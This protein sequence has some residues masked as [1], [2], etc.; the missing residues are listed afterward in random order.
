MSKK[1]VLGI[2]HNQNQATV[3]V[4]ALVRAGFP[5]SDISV[6]F[7]G[8]GDSRD[9]AIEKGTKAPEGAVAGGGTGGIVGGTLGL[10]AGL[11]A[12]AIPGVGPLV[13]AGP[14]MAAL[15]G[16]AVGATVGSI[17]GGLIGLGIPEINARVYEDK[18]KAGNVLVAVHTE[19][20][21]KVDLAKRVLE[22]HKADD[23]VTTSEAS[24]PKK[25][26]A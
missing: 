19:T 26:V 17:A 25:N 4:D 9:F 5:S 23:V 16:L 11:G 3:V 20:S 6:L 8:T 15:S 2:V 7:P 10:L 12:L 21:E 18:I 1:T 14:I 24:V 22:E 13:A